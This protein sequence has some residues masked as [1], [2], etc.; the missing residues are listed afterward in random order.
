MKKSIFIKLFSFLL[1]FTGAYLFGTGAAFLSEHFHSDHSSHYN[2]SSQDVSQSGAVPVS[3]DGNWGLSFQEDGQLPT[4]NATME[5]LAQYDAYYAQDTD[6]KVLYLTFDAG[7]ENGNTEPI[8]DAL[9]KHNVSATFF[10]VGTYIESEPELVKRM[11]EEGHT[12][13]NHTWH[14]PDMSQIADMDSFKK[15]I[16]DVEDAFLAVTGQEMTK[17]YRPPQ[18]KYNKANLQM[19]KELGYKTF[20]WSLA[21]VDWYQDDQPTEEEAF[22]K[23]LGR[24]HPGAIVLLHSTSSTNAAILD[25]LLTKW[26]EMG[27]QI[28]PL[29]ELIQ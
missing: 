4:G 6:E 13:G 12:V 7:Y 15:E 1:L 3:A 5:E 2:D 20:F 18:G 22:D 29:S 8:L 21:Y 25:E 27:Y 17:Y 24:I 10:V 28:R 14:H 26:E 11:V 9:K 16:T 19:A 23:L